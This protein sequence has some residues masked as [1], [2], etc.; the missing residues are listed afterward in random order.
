MTVRSESES[1]LR[2][3]PCIPKKYGLQRKTSRRSSPK[4]V[5][6]CEKYVHENA[7][8]ISCR[9][10]ACV[11]FGFLIL[12]QPYSAYRPIRW[13]AAAS[14]RGWRPAADKT[15]FFT[16]ATS[17]SAEP[18]NAFAAARTPLSWWFSLPNCFS[19]FLS[20]RWIAAR[21]F[22]NPPREIYLNPRAGHQMYCRR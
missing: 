20:S 7:L 10:S 11:Y 2:D 6:V 15:R 13:D 5:K 21:M 19:S 4:S 8:N 18:P 12:S 1:I 16:P 3:C 9:P 17:R 14:Q 22:M